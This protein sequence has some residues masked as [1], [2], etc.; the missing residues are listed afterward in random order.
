MSNCKSHFR[1]LSSKPSLEETTERQELNEDFDDGNETDT[2][3]TAAEL[4]EKYVR[5]RLKE[6][7]N[8]LN[9]IVSNP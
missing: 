6:P 4:A 9:C 3:T 1:L 7:I 5:S 8:L 2:T